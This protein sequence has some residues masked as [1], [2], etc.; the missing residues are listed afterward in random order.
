[1]KN[2]EHYVTLFDSVFL[3]QALALQASMQRHMPGNYRLWMLCVDD[4]AFDLLD[5]LKLPHCTALKLSSLETP[6]LLQVKSQRSRAEYCWTLTPFA[7]RFVFEA[8]PEVR[9]VTYIDT[10]LWFRKD[11]SP[12]FD[13][14]DASGAKVLIT[15]HG[16]APEHDQTALS[17]Q[18]CVQFM[19]FEREGGE[20]VRQWWEDR[21]I[22]WCYARFEDGK[23]GDQRY[24]DDWPSRF[25]GL[26]HVLTRLEFTQAPWNATRYPY[27]QAIFYHFQGLRLL[28]GRRIDL[29]PT[30]ALPAPLIENVYD[31]Y[32]A[33][34]GQAIARLESLG[35]QIRPQGKSLGWLALARRALSGVYQQLW[36]FHKLRFRKY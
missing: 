19:T 11:P 17:G 30:Y 34:L 35:V 12:I 14:F 29:A 16:Y 7:P 27:G 8:S 25:K 36:R 24:L 33:D 13:E 1:M 23:F 26:V 15:D 10:D 21:C 6:T 9:R 5:Q 32:L 18:Y 31:P 22:E 28:P 3:P 20:T 4:L 2:V